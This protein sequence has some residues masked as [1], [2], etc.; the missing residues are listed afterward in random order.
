MEGLTGAPHD[1]LMTSLRRRIHSTLAEVAAAAEAAEALCAEAGA[2]ESQAL[3]IGLALDELAANAL[4]H[5]AVREE[6]PDILVEVWTDESELTL[7]VSA[8]GPRFDPREP[9]EAPEAFAGGGRGLALVLAFA[10]RL[11][12]ERDGNRNVTTF[13]VA[14]HGDPEVE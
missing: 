10:D 13:T 5:G 4:V 2:D 8:S 7:R 12:Y 14:K 3:R 11:T 9:R 6:A 1:A